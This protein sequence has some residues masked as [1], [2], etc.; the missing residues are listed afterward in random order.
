MYVDLTEN[1]EFPQYKSLSVAWEDEK[2]KMILLKFKSKGYKYFKM[3]GKKGNYEEFVLSKCDRDY[4][5]K[6]ITKDNKVF[7][8]LCYLMDN[9]VY[10]K[11][12]KRLGEIG[13]FIEEYTH[14]KGFPMVRFNIK[15]GLKIRDV[16]MMKDKYIKLLK[17]SPNKVPILVY[18]GNG[19]VILDYNGINRILG[20][21]L[22]K[23]YK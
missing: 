12:L 20:H 17:K 22:N 10:C 13:E 7:N 4:T 5:T 3:H 2:I 1:R 14:R 11:E 6:L 9:H 18:E 15:F 8:F 16:T 23:N 19:A 21:N